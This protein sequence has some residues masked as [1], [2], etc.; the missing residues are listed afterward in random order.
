VNSPSTLLGRIRIRRLF[1]LLGQGAQPFWLG[2]FKAVL[3]SILIALFTMD[4][5]DMG[6]QGFLRRESRTTDGTGKLLGH[7]SACGFAAYE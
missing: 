3:E 7:A 4:L 1:L 2:S 5:A 6:E